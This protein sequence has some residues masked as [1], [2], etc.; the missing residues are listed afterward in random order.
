MSSR[1]R[2]HLETKWSATRSCVRGQLVCYDSINARKI[3]VEN[4]VLR[5][6]RGTVHRPEGHQLNCYYFLKCWYA[7][8][9]TGEKRPPIVFF[10]SESGVYVSSSRVTV[11]RR[12]Q[13]AAMLRSGFK[14]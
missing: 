9:L 5:R 11:G 4:A 1:E 10:V 6:K 14:R 2:T 13:K 12:Q 3:C 8:K 7:G